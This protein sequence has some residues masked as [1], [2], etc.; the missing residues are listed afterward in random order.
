MKKIT[1]TIRVTRRFANRMLFILSALTIVT[2]AGLTMSFVNKINAKTIVVNANNLDYTYETSKKTVQNFLDENDIELGEND[3]I[4]FP[5]DYE[6]FDG[7]TIK[8]NKA[9][10]VRLYLNGKLNLVY[11]SAKTVSE[12][13]DE[14]NI[15]M[16]PSDDINVS[17]DTLIINNIEIIINLYDTEI[18]EA[19]EDIPFGIIYEL[20]NS[21]PEGETKIKQIGQPGVKHVIYQIRYINGRQIACDELQEEVVASPINQ[22]V[23]QGTRKT[24]SFNGKTYVVK[25]TLKMTST[26]YDNCYLCCGKNP[27]DP[28]YGVTAS[29]MKTKYGVVAV[30]PRIIPL[31]TKLYVEGYGEAIAADT[32]S[33]IKGYKI[34]LY[35]PT[36]EEAKAYGLHKDIQVFILE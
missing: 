6:I 18:V 20:S 25:E 5:L 23:L 33:A 36:H 4:N 27:G 30:D 14:Q 3:K 10:P 8:I 28:G 29:G 7:M 2:I 22:I 11:S 35:F 16:L 24:V 17:L 32:G 19:T 26:G 15:K 12:F 13:L 9:V 1:A 21:I 31:G 34:D